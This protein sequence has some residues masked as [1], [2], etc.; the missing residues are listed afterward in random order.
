MLG[1]VLEF[2]HDRLDTCTD[3]G[4]GSCR[5]LLGNLRA[6]ERFGIATRIHPGDLHGQEPK[7]LKRVFKQ[8]LA[9]LNAGK[10]RC[11]IW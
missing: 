5:Q 11:S 9:R 7:N 6:A 2:G 3:Y 4:D 10:L 1:S 8:S